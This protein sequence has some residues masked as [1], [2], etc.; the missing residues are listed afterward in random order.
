MRA[1]L[2]AERG[3]VDWLRPQDLSPEA[4]ADAVTATLAG[5]GTTVPVRP[6]DL[7]GRR[8]GTDRLIESLG[9]TYAPRMVPPAPRGPAPTLLSPVGAVRDDDY[10]LA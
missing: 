3:W 6:P 9:R 5:P 8:T 7:A 10:L 1:R 2:F 4:L